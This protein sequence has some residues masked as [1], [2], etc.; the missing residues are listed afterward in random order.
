VGQFQTGHED[1]IALLA[2]YSGDAKGNAPS[3][4]MAAQASIRE[5]TSAGADSRITYRR[6]GSVH[7]VGRWPITACSQRGWLAFEPVGR[8]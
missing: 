5:C 4:C 3:N 6:L 7:R 8:A 2:R 1:I